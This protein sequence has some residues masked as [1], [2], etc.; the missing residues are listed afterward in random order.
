MENDRVKERDL[1]ILSGKRNKTGSA[2]ATS[3]FLHHQWKQGDNMDLY[4][5]QRYLRT[6]VL[7]FMVPSII[8]A[9]ILAP[10]NYL[11]GNETENRVNGLD[12]LSWSNIG[13]NH[14]DCYWAHFLLSICLG[15]YTC[16]IVWWELCTYIQIRQASRNCALR[17]VLIDGIPP[18]WTSEKKLSEVLEC[19]GR[20]TQISFNQDTR[21]IHQRLQERQ[22]IALLLEKAETELIRKRI[23]DVSRRSNHKLWT[24]GFSSN[25]IGL[26]RE[27]LRAL[28]LEISHLASEVPALPS[29]FVTFETPIAA[30]IA[31][32]SVIHHQ[33]AY[34]TPRAM[35]ISPSDV[36]WENISLPWWSRTIRSVVCNIAILA[37][38]V[39][40]AA[41]I[42]LSSLLSQALYLSR[43]AYLKWL[44]KLPNWVLG[45]IQGLLPP[46]CLNI[47]LRIF[48]KALGFLVRKQGIPLRS[49]SSL[50]F[51]DYYFSFLLVQLTISVTLSAGLTVFMS[52]ISSGGEIATTLAQNLPK[53][54]NYFIS[55]VV[56]QALS[57]SAKSLLRV[58]SL[59][60]KMVLSPLM[61]RTVS[62]LLERNKDSEIEWGTFIPVYTNLA[63]IGKLSSWCRTNL[64][65]TQG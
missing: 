39:V 8:V 12:T 28:N 29:A 37:T 24:R 21:L 30:S 54:S 62:Q 48:S 63:C 64:T 53:A 46:V 65:E 1:T 58:D 26:H 42:S 56:L 25:R 60:Q 16:W 45:I 31:C 32:Q 41:P 18:L 14:T 3:N 33:A 2:I 49:L 36:I 43:F 47:L 59:V 27:H 20:T 38:S 19:F 51:Q 9:P 44:Q 40:C 61:D 50:K 52:T 11:Q 22:T 35:P 13:P 57:I 6:L 5:F 10:L 17:T 4:F 7:L 23:T 55:Y 15:T 34:M